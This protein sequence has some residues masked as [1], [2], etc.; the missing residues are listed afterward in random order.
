MSA[1]ATRPEDDTAPTTPLTVSAA[2]ERCATCDAPL[3]SDQRY[4]VNC[5]ARRG[6]P[7]FTPEAVA[8]Q[9]LPEQA[10]VTE[11]VIARQ[12]RVSQA[13]TLV[14]GAATKVLGSSAPKKPTVA[15]GQK[16]ASDTAGCKNG[17][18][19]GSFFGP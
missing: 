2:G 10:L 12:P 18:F 11:R 9:A 17:K 6:R 4:C 19:S 5:G 1:Q 13:T 7:R 16:C 14:A 15:V 8:A 3:A